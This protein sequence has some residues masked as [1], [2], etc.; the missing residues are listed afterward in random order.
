MARKKA[1]TWRSTASREGG[2]QFSMSDIDL[3][4]PDE[5]T[6][7]DERT[8]QKGEGIGDMD[9]SNCVTVGGVFTG[10]DHGHIRGCSCM[11]NHA[12]DADHKNHPERFR[13][14]ATNPVWHGRGSQDS[15]RLHAS[16]GGPILRPEKCFAPSPARLSEL[17]PT[18]QGIEASW[19]LAPESCAPVR[20]RAQIG[21]SDTEEN[22]HN[23]LL[24]GTCSPSITSK[25]PESSDRD[26]V[27][28]KRELERGASRHVLAGG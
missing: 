7:G 16:T 18:V 4:L 3:K 15:A 13:T 26:R 14:R 21:I 19:T 12:Y 22:I 11:S 1:R 17:N 2:S 20:P 8:T 25:D 10:V 28:C 5:E 23:A 6:L 27:T 9:F 24:A